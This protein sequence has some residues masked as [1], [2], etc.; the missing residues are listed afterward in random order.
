MHT[1]R[2]DEILVHIFGGARPDKPGEP[3]EGVTDTSNDDTEY[4]E[5]NERRLFPQPPLTIKRKAEPSQE[6]KAL[7]IVMVQQQMAQNED[8]A[9]SLLAG[10][11]LFQARNYK[12]S[13]AV[14]NAGRW[15]SVE[16]GLVTGAGPNLIGEHFLNPCSDKLMV[17]RKVNCL[18]S[19]LALI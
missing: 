13:T 2:K 11:A 16:D 1:L 3:Q 4:T 15:N 12:V 8:E 10:T 5:P 18:R 6:A 17:K 19:R 9:K 7:C 14:D